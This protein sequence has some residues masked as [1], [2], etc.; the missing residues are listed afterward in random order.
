M[1]TLP[2]KKKLELIILTIGIV[3]LGII[4]SQQRKMIPDFLLYVIVLILVYLGVVIEIL[5]FPHS[6]KKYGVSSWKEWDEKQK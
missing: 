1:R 6:R 5:F 3:I 2:K 4:F